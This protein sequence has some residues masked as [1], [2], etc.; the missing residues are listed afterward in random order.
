MEGLLDVK[1]T[2]TF[3]NS[4]SSK[5]LHSYMPYQNSFNNSDEIRIVINQSDLIVHPASSFL[6]IEGTFLKED[7][8]ESKTSKLVNNS[9][10][11]L[12]DNI[13]YYLN[14]VQ[15]DETKNLGVATTMKGYASFNKDDSQT[16]NH[17]GWNL[18]SYLIEDGNFSFCVPLKSLMGL[19]EDYKKIF[20][21]SKHE[22][23]L[24]R[25]RS[26]LNAFECSKGE[27][28]NLTINKIVWKIPHLQLN[29]KE[30]LE[31]LRVI[32]SNKPIQSWFRSWDMV[33]WP[34]LPSI[35]KHFWSIKT[36]TQL[37]KP[38]FV[39][40][41]FQTD[42][43]NNAEKNMAHFDH[44]SLRNIK[45][46]LNSDVFPYENLNLDYTKNLYSIHYEMYSRFQE[47]YYNN[48]NR[49]IFTFNEFK[50]KAPLCV[51]DCSHQSES[52][53]SSTVDIRLEFETSENIP[54]N[55][56]LY[57]LIIHDKLIEYTPLTSSVRVL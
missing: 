37:E 38:R 36:S 28:M 35:D 5:Q 57:C 24:V 29:D 40:I 23:V 16:L 14:G 18:E 42:R 54:A 11:H 2:A 10:C 20:I 9:M 33:E 34:V 39:I 50:T 8:K 17:T 56:S 3:D 32:E 52:L 48:V 21:N 30:R 31:I 49:P 43:K 53:R 12:F 51:I 41:G 22:L 55:T 15:I 27:N 45:L 6:Y 46:H 44:C 7:K 19:C 26:D 47:S 1:Q 4:I 13:R 25:S